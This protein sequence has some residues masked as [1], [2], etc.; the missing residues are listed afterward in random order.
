MLQ[1]R[2]APRRPREHLLM[3]HTDQQQIRE[4]RYTKGLLDAS[5]LRTDLV[6]SQP[7][8]RLQC[9]LDPLHGPPSLIRPPHLSRRPRVQMGQQDFRIR[10]ILAVYEGT[11]ELSSRY[12]PH[13]QLLKRQT[14][15][16]ES[17]K[18]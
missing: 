10:F 15:I 14:A 7:E 2:H 18:H 6:L 5:L 8:V 11:M 3:A 4:H 17:F 9:A 13:K 16:S 1:L 12:T